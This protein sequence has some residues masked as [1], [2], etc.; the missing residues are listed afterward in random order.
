MYYPTFY[1]NART[2]GLYV[3]SDALL[4]CSNYIYVCTIRR[5]IKNAQ[6][7]GMLLRNSVHIMTILRRQPYIA[8]IC[9]SGNC[10]IYPRSKTFSRYSIDLVF[11]KKHTTL[12]LVNLFLS[13]MT[14][15]QVKS[16]NRQGGNVNKLCPYTPWYTRRCHI[17]C[18]LE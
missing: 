4:K 1:W 9:W 13:M 17:L 5:F 18:V 6:T 14:K 12:T 2:T 10:S 15:V 3:L 8:N 16:Y 7:I 11:N